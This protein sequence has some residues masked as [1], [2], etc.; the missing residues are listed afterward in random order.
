[1]D[2]IIV[3]AGSGRRLNAGI[4][5]VF[6][7]LAGEPIFAH[8][9]RKLAPFVD[10][11]VLVVKEEEAKLVEPYLNEQ[12]VLA[13][14]GSERYLSVINGLAK[15]KSDYVLIHDGARPFLD[16]KK[17]ADLIDKAPSYEAAMLYKKEVNTAY[18]LA[19]GQ[20]QGL[21]REQIILA[22]TPQIVKKDLYLAALAKAKTDGL[23]PTDDFS[24][25]LNYKPDLAYYLVED[26]DNFKI[27]T[28]L[29]YELAK[30]VMKNA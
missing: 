1:M 17:L 18:Y 21:N 2:A 23:R 27:T 30:L 13:Y 28:A 9:L 22:S 11:I 20:L 19:A 3:M 16:A 15:T 4:N 26:Q 5:K 10:R 6:L 8:S 24:L 25:L 12:V 7:D 14:G 29:D